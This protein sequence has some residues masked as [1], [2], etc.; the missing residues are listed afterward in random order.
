MDLVGYGFRRNRSGSEH[1]YT[2]LKVPKSSV[3][4]ADPGTVAFLPGSPTH[5]S[6]SLVTI[7]LVQITLLLWL[8][9]FLNLFK[10]RGRSSHIY[11]CQARRGLPWNFP[12]T[13][14]T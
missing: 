13:M 2:I 3:A 14:R 7:F 10:N 8:K 1:V 9:L 12:L 4:E 5:I 11:L 6:E